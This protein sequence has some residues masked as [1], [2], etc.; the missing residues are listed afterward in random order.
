[1]KS[2]QISQSGGHDIELSANPVIVEESALE[3]ALELA[4]Y[5]SE[6]ADSN[7]D[8]PKIVVWLGEMSKSPFCD[9]KQTTKDDKCR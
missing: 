5:S 6:S 2:S 4:G 3:S 1:M 9:H 8:S 7:A